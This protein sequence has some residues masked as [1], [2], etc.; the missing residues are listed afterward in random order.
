[1]IG[2]RRLIRELANDLAESK[3]QAWSAMTECADLRIFNHELKDQVDILEAIIV[4][5]EIE[6][7]RGAS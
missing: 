7:L 6:L 2:A 1:M 3:A 5:Q 4:E